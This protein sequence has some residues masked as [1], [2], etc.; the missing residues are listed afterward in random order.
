MKL[1][2][3]CRKKDGASSA[4]CG[5]ALIERFIGFGKYKNYGGK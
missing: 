2:I 1:C 3:L 4:A 5:P